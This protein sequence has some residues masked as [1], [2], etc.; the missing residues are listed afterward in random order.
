MNIKSRAKV[1][2]DEGVSYDLVKFQ[3]CKIAVKMW[4]RLVEMNEDD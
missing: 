1:L 2:E 3:V 4:N